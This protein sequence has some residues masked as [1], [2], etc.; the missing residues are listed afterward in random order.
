MYEINGAIFVPIL[1]L[2]AEN[3][4]RA[5]RVLFLIVAFSFSDKQVYKYFEMHGTIL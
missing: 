3:T 4:A 5:E 1:V 2:V